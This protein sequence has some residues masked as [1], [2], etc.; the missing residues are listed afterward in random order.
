MYCARVI[1]I[2]AVPF[3]LTSLVICSVAWANANRIAPIKIEWSYSD[4]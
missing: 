4:I 3:M 2:G 1:T